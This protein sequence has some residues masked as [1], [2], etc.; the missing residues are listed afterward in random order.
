[1]DI[2]GHELQKLERKCRIVKLCV[3]RAKRKFPYSTRS[4]PVIK[5]AQLTIRIEGTSEK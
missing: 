2:N 1:M 4:S 5:F 3:M